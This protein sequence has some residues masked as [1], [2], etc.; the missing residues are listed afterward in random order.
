MGAS[1]SNNKN[2]LDNKFI[3]NRKEILIFQLEQIKNESISLTKK[4]LE[5]DDPLFKIGKGNID[6]LENLIDICNKPNNPNKENKNLSLDLDN[7]KK[8][9][10][11]KDVFNQL[12]GYKKTLED[13]LKIFEELMLTCGR[14]LKEIKTSFEDIK[15]EISNTNKKYKE[16]LKILLKPLSYINE[17]F[18]IKK[19]R[20][21]KFKD[22]DILDQCKSSI[23][24]LQNDFKSYVSLINIFN[25]Q[26]LCQND[27][28]IGVNDDLYNL[29]K[30]KLVLKIKEIFTLINEGIILIDEKAERINTFNN[31]IKTKKISNKEYK[32]FVDDIKDEVLKKLKSIDN[33]IYNS[34]NNFIFYFD[35]SN[36]LDIV[37]KE[38]IDILKNGERRTKVLWINVMD[39]IEKIIKLF[40]KKP[41]KI[42][43]NKYNI[44][45]PFYEYIPKFDKG[46]KIVQEIKEEFQKS[47]ISVINSFEKQIKMET[48]DL[49]IIMGTIPS[50]QD[51]LDE[52]RNSIYYISE[53]IKRDCPGIEIRYAF[54]GFIDFD[55][56]E[57]E[58]EYYTIDFEID[59]DVFKKKLEE[60]V[61]KGRR[62]HAIDVA[63]GLD[64][65][66]YMSWR[67]S[68]RYAILLTDSP[69]HGRLYH[70][71]YILDD[72]P[73]RHPDALAL[74]DIMKN[75][76]KK[77]INLCLTRIDCSTDKMFGVMIF[78][79]NQ[80]SQKSKEKP[81]IQLL[82]Y[83]KKEK[84][85]RQYNNIKKNYKN[86]ENQI[87][88]KKF[89]PT[90]NLG[91]LISKTAAEIYKPYS[92]K[93]K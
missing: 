48:L 73:E 57:E 4:F 45:F 33:I 93:Y 11:D 14:K 5:N 60:I 72:C 86:K 82:N 15:T 81:K 71:N 74:E 44:E 47:M 67:S 30:N 22:V 50:M 42:D 59:I 68:A 77:N 69:E 87:D 18:D 10:L 7:I 91:D 28:F 1:S 20:N 37:K 25:S 38:G 16:S 51:I 84:E 64:Y 49:L 26:I 29:I 75:Y 79:Y 46:V 90:S 23:Y 43:Y 76:V 65:G 41:L 27:Y 85:Y 56:I 40:D 53:K 78:A 62:F 13:S 58:E 34:Y 35:D 3:E 80:E 54:E 36:G 92:I 8:D 83:E 32:K 39:D 9:K 55:D 6:E 89:K 2:L 19:F 21:K 24:L 12:I 88:E 17:E 70:D 61:V 66:Y 31:D 52:F 63:G